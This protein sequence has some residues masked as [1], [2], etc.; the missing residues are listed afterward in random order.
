MGVG[1]D[2]GVAVVEEVDGDGVEGLDK[3]EGVGFVFE[4][5]FTDNNIK[6]LEVERERERSI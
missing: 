5:N 1:D 2:L 4:K 3:G 6:E